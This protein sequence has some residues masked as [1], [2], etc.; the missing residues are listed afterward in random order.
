MTKE[1]IRVEDRIPPSFTS[2][3]AHRTDAWPYQSVR[4]AFIIPGGW[5]TPTRWYFPTLREC[6]PVDMWRPF[7]EPPEEA[8]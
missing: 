4:E 7:D 2:V 8:H 6:H 5:C 3:Q 1:W